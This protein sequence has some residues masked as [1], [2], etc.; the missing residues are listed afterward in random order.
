MKKITSILCL[1][2]IGIIP[3]M[4]HTSHQSTPHIHVTESLSIGII[5]V[6][7]VLIVA[8]LLIKKQLKNNRNRA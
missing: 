7:T 4:A 2:L 6:F 1:S 8:T 5:T 3:A